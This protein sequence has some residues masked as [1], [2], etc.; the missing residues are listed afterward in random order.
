[1]KH[2]FLSVLAVCGI[3]TIHAQT[4]ELGIN[5]GVVSTNG[6]PTVSTS[7]SFNDAFCDQHAAALTTAG[8]S[9]K[10]MYNYKKWQLGV[11]AD[12]TNIKYNYA[13]YQDGYAGFFL[14]GKTTK[15]ESL[16]PVKLFLNRKFICHKWE[17]YVGVAAG[18]VLKITGD[19]K[20]ITEFSTDAGRHRYGIIAGVQAGTT[21][22]ISKKIGINAQAVADYMPVLVEKAYSH[23]KIK[24]INYPI[25]I[26]LLYKL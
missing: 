2:F 13:F 6:S 24:L 23:E 20:A 18:Y 17:N 3:A 4:F 12:Y 14:T 1:M 26:G 8:V 9:V 19:D 16:I 21:Y 15:T 11:G 10:A 25:T 7:G 22:F 5:G